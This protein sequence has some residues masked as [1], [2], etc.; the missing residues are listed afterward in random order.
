MAKKILIIE[1]DSFFAQL[2]QRGLEKYGFLVVRAADGEE[3]LG[4]LKEQKPDLVILDI[5]MPRMNGLDVLKKIR[6]EE[7]NA[8]LAKVP[9]IMLTNLYQK[10]DVETSKLL[11][12][13]AF[14]VKATTDIDQ[15]VSEIE[16]I[17]K[18]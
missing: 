7:A 4:K 16:K 12:A 9:V 5:I 18:K 13:S 11:K 1:D 14:L 10:E 17:F 3:G 8:E 2:C 15:L 6:Q